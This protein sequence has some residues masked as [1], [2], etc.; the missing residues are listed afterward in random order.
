MKEDDSV[1]R[2]FAWLATAATLTFAL[3]GTA[4]QDDPRLDGL[5]DKLKTS[6]DVSEARALEQVIWQVWLASG[7]DKIDRIMT[8]GMRAMAFNDHAAALKAFDEMVR[9]APGFAEGW[10][11]RATV[12]YMAGD[13]AASAADIE[14]TLALEPRHFGALSGLGLVRLAQGDE[15]AALA[16]FEAALDVYPHLPGADSHIKE[17]RQR[18]KGKRI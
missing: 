8:H 4:A 12:H 5:F 16:A 7:D 9:L 18:V 13:M 10:N 2:F 6:R 17:L 15:A 11:K 14:R 3:P 1:K